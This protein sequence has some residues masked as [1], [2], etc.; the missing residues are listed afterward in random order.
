MWKILKCV[1][2]SLGRQSYCTVGHLPHFSTSCFFLASVRRRQQWHHAEGS[3]THVGG[4]K[5][6]G[7]CLT[8]IYV[9][10][11]HTYLVVI[12][13]SFLFTQL[14][15]INEKWAKEYRTMKQFY[16]EKVRKS[17]W[18]PLMV[19]VITYVSF[20]DF[21]PYVMCPSLHP[22]LRWM[23]LN[24]F[25]STL[26]LKRRCVKKWTKTQRCTRRSKMIGARG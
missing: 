26:T 2:G 22:M 18:V 16:R 9:D 3:D 13:S 20:Q 14:L 23:I 15:S 12:K 5:E 10:S 1:K 17:F 7:E 24:H 6:R 25:M 4:A 21:Q 19:C 11:T 8:L